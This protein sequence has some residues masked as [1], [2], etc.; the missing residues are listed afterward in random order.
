M[1]A[2]SLQPA[3]HLMLLNGFSPFINNQSA[4]INGNSISNQSPNNPLAAVA[5]AAAAAAAVSAQ[6]QQQ[7]NNNQPGPNSLVFSGGRDTISHNQSTPTSL[8]PVSGHSHH[9]GQTMLKD[10]PNP[11]PVTNAP[12]NLSKPKSLTH[13][14]ATSE[15]STSRPGKLLFCF[16]IF[17]YSNNR[18]DLI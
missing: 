9:N 3:A 17:Q 6:Q 15:H 1:A 12:L 16:D 14:S 4:L 13:R 8:S 5:A 7:S 11:E 18:F 10:E 2:A